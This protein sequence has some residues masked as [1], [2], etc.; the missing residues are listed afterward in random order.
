MKTGEKAATCTEDGNIE[1]YTC[2]SCGLIFSDSDGKNEIS[3]EETVIPASGHQQGEWIIDKKP[4][5]TAEGSKHIECTVCGEI[6]ERKAIPV[7]SSEDQ[8]T[9]NKVTETDDGFL[10][11]DV[12]RTGDETDVIPWILILI[13]S[14]GAASAAGLKK[15]GK[16][17]KG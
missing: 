4:T 3:I 9:D 8:E 10:E 17:G 2:R 7:L 11:D 13:L 1:Y 6:L 14:L 16:T 5:E 12:V 15:S